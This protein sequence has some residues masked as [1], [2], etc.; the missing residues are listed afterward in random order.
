MQ[1]V[2]NQVAIIENSIEVLKTGPE[3]LQASQLRK[4]K[5]ITVGKNILQSITENGMD[6]ASDERAMKYLVNVATANKEMK[7]LRAGVTQ[8]MDQLKKMYTEVENELDVKKPGTI[9][10]QLQQHRDE[11]VKKQAAEA[12]RKRKEA[13]REAAKK[14]EAIELRSHVEK[15]ITEKLLALLAAKKQGLTNAFNNITLE[16][17]EEKSAGL[18]K[19][20]THILNSE[21][22]E[23]IGKL[24]KMPYAPNHSGEEAYAIRDKEFAAYDFK[25]WSINV[26]QKEITELKTDL[27]EKLPSKKAELD[28]QKRLADEAAAELEKNRLAEKARNE[29]I[30]SANA[31]QKKKLEAEAAVAREK[32]A[33]RAA[34]LKLEQEAAAAAQREREA[35]ENARLA[36]VAEEN[37]IAA[38]QAAEVKKQGDQ[39]MVLF[40]QEAA[41]ADVAAPEA[42]QGFD[43][44][45]LHP[46]GYTQIFALWFEKVGK[47][48]P[49]DKIGNTKLDQMKAWAEKAAHKDGTK[50]ESKFLNYEA[51]FKA[52]NKKEKEK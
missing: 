39:T 24:D 35:A 9:P 12:E 27:L 25:D 51:S 17:Y 14:K 42:R 47:D 4:D 38:E 10:A 46:V 28:E 32:E 6:Q 40:E 20:A 50:I 2:N 26:W 16:N 44:T 45:V 22:I 11:Y 5:A 43:I 21:L 49:I 31:A 18:Q 30:A 19:L 8:I 23:K 7:E 33:A 41:M 48:L 37:R 15:W 29:A 13:E 34:Q 3:I 36:K 1:E 52:V